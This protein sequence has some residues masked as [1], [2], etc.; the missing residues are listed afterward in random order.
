MSLF[1]SKESN[2]YVLCPAYSKT[3]GPELLHQLVNEL[4][5]NGINAYITY[6]GFKKYDT[7]YTPDDFKKYITDYKTLIE[8]E[9]K[10]ENIV[11]SP[12][13]NWA[14]NIVK[15]IKNAQK[16]IWWLSVDNFERACG[17]KNTLK[18]YGIITTPILM[19]KRE[20]IYNFSDMNIFDK[21]LCQSHYAIK[22]LEKKGINNSLYLSDY[23][24]DEYLN[25]K[26]DFNGKEDIILYNPKKGQKFTKKIIEKANDLKFVPIQN[27]TTNQV[28]EL[29][30]KSKVYIDF[31][32]HPGKDRIPREAAMCGCCIIT[33]KRG[34]A[35]YHEDVPI[36]NEFKFEDTTE[37]I[38][39]IIK[40]IKDCIENYDNEINKFDNYR[41]FIK[42][43]KQQFKS[44]IKRIFLES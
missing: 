2:V 11:I 42:Q 1:I 20:M 18:T 22:Y 40:K 16:I 21:H 26:N 9:D 25:I 8:I 10:K 44:D 37:N 35:K 3:G 12:E 36:D 32:N 41:R 39:M 34:S 4:N 7:N 19:L 24:S 28:K 17:L 5:N 31:G 29:L 38:E 33:N 23:V 30:L 6:F 43:E 15:K 27:L 13:I 14:I